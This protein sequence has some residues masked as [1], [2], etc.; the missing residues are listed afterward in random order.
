MHYYIDG[1]NLLFRSSWSMQSHNL[2]KMRMQLI[3]EL[4]AEI[5]LI[6]LQ[7]TI[8]F[9]A[10]LQLDEMR[11]SHFRSL[12]I[13]FTSHGQTADDFLITTFQELDDP[14]NACLISSDRDLQK[15]AKGLGVQSQGIKEFLSWLR[16]RSFKKR[17]YKKPLPASQQKPSSPPS[18][19]KKRQVTDKKLAKS[20]SRKKEELPDLM[21]IPRWEKLFEDILYDT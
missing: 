7:V 16:K 21:D 1:Y 10:P 11:K 9:D 19:L 8:V 18:L 3:E 14:Q 20:S 6:H 5:S 17:I 12:E 13:I 2:E 15:R 4:D